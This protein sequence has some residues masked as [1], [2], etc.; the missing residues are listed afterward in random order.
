MN[1]I[2][3]YLK[4]DDVAINVDVHDKREAILHAA[5]LVETFYDIDRQRTFASLWRREQSGSTAVGHGMAIPHGRIGGLKDPIVLALRL[6]K[7]INF[8]A[9]DKAPVDFLFVILV[10][11]EATEQHLRILSVVAE[12]LSEA[13]FRASLRDAKDSVEIHRLLTTGSLARV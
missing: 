11:D 7:A 8:G 5:K 10:S 1:L 12:H 9:T 3:Y 13:W 4:P 2:G 6:A